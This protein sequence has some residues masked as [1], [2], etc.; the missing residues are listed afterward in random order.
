MHVELN[1]LLE[2]NRM[3]R[4]TINCKELINE[5]AGSSGEVYAEMT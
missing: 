2:T 1:E 5:Q 4:A 3:Q